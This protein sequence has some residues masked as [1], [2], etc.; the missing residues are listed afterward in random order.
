MG[1]QIFVNGPPGVGKTTICRALCDA[2]ELEHVA[3][4]DL[5]RENILRQTELG[6]VAKKCITQRT[7]IPDHV[8]IE[9]VAEKI[10]ECGKDH[11]GWVLDGFPRTVD[12]YD[13]LRRKKLLP[14][15][16]ILLGLSEKDCIQ[17]L[18]GRR[19]DP[20]TSRI[21][22][23]VWMMPKDPTV[24]ARLT[25]RSDDAVDKVRPRM[26]AYRLH[27]ELVNAKFASISHSVDASPSVEQITETLVALLNKP[28][29]SD[30]TRVASLPLRSVDFSLSR[31]PETILE[32]REEDAESDNDEDIVLQSDPVYD[33]AY[34]ANGDVKGK[35]K[36]FYPVVDPPAV[37]ESIHPSVMSSVI[38]A[39]EELQRLKDPAHAASLDRFASL[40]NP[41]RLHLSDN[42]RQSTSETILSDSER[43]S[44]AESE[45]PTCADTEQTNE[46]SGPEAS[47]VESGE[48]D[49]DKFREMLMDGFEAVKHGRRGSPHNRLIYT[50]MDFKRIFW[51][52]PTKEKRPKRGNLDQSM[53]L[54]D[55]LQVVRGIK[56][57]VLRRTGDVAKYERYLSLVGDDRT[58]DLEIPSVELCDFLFQ[59]FEQLLNPMLVR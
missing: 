42:Q 56:T 5:L 25:K 34:H 53:V 7:L 6:I 39:E 48:F 9:M 32:E 30:S 1:F 50:D 4:G 49:M 55:M 11:R 15:V 16:A 19:F 43:S 29:P 8:V 40:L 58:L 18:S 28:A 14:R 24:H 52:K 10:R 38:I 47:L 2:F 13:A 17:R 20:V 44:S 59:G 12:Q 36:P 23:T 51:Q 37:R 21:Y 46:S 33:P 57:E 41:S 31:R 45:K 22:H 27:G 35:L 3:T 26:D 54:S